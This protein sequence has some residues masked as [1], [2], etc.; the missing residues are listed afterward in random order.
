MLTLN[1]EL[2]GQVYR[3]ALWLDVEKRLTIQ[4]TGSINQISSNTD[5]K[6]PS[7]Q[8]GM[9]NHLNWSKF[10]LL[11]STPQTYTNYLTLFKGR[12][13]PSLLP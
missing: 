12:P 13:K 11:I 1:K 6:L 9:V 4:R 3:E 2:V 7:S 5:Q 8:A 10:D